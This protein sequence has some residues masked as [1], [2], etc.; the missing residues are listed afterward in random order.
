VRPRISLAATTAAVAALGMSPG[1][2][3]TDRWV[4][5]EGPLVAEMPADPGT[6]DRIAGSA[7]QARYDGQKGEYRLLGDATIRRG[8]RQISGER[9]NYSEAEQTV[10]AEGDVRLR[11]P[12]VAVNARRGQFRLSDDTGEAEDIN[13]R[14]A[15]GHLSGE[16]GRVSFLGDDRTRYEEVTLTTCEPG[17]EV[18]EL[19]ASEVTID[20]GRGQG[21]AWNARLA[22]GDVPV[23]YTPWLQFPVGSQRQTGLLAP[24]LGS[25]DDDGLTTGLPFYWNIA[26]NYD[27]TITPRLFQ[28]RGAMLDTQFRYL[29]P[30]IAGEIR[31]TYLPS[32]DR[33]GDDRWAI[34]QAHRVASG[35]HLRARLEQQRVSDPDYPKDF[36]N[37]LDG[38]RERF[39][40]SRASATWSESDWSISAD[41][42]DW[43]TIDQTI[44]PVNQPL[45][46]RPRLRARY[47]PV[48]TLGP[49]WI[50][51]GTEIEATRF[52]HPVASQRDT[53]DRWD[54]TARISAPVETL[55]YFIEPGV[56]VRHTRYD[57]ERPGN[58]ATQPQ[59]TVPSYSLDAGLFLE[60][61]A[62]L[63]GEATK[64]TLEPR[65]FLLYTPERDQDELP[66]FDTQRAQLTFDQLF[67]VN[68]FT[69]AD[70]VGDA[71]QAS[72][73]LT[74][75]LVDQSNGREY[76]SIA[77]GGIVYFADRAVTLDG[78]PETKELSELIG[79]AELDL[80]GGLSARLDG[81]VDPKET[82][83]HEWRTALRYRGSA[84]VIL[85]GQYRTRQVAGSRVRET[86]N[87]SAALPI[88]RRWTVFGG[89][90]YDLIERASDTGFTGL[91]Y[92]DCCYAVR[93]VYRSTLDPQTQGGTERDNTFLLQVELKGLGGVGNEI[94]DF[95]NDA[96]PGY[97]RP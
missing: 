81:L 30:W 97:Q 33:F 90:R 43:Q 67:R 55:G 17:E 47:E 31:T 53:G 51:Y 18:W 39:L 92:E 79:K 23:A 69:G 11:E 10:D 58:Q 80:P 65:L 56:Q 73:G 93:G 89:I 12:G 8:D 75:R 74:S 1:F 16:A 78:Q 54:A 94:T 2:A 85:N 21:E 3:Q 22:V 29:R 71:Q 87:A 77:G 4:Y 15:Q 48:T 32:D 40:E 50:D 24:I 37:S 27:A 49:T 63:F 72:W 68:R 7:E 25:N 5:C 57:L 20:Q 13:Y 41:G 35:T 34:N 91:Q 44:A 26:P 45:A 59:R 70:R 19:R 46:R 83:N 62:P 96:V 82:G 86:A 14:F 36:D 88:T 84:G 64:Q 61:P 52:A 60:R 28:K 38:N 66:V 76:F 42:Q 9:L 95:L 6:G